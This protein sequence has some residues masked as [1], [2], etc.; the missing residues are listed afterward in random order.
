VA[1][2]REQGLE[3]EPVLFG[4][5]RRPEAA[6]LPYEMF[7]LLLDLAEDAAIAYRVRERIAT[8]DGARVSLADVAAELGVNLDEL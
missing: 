4:D 3:A 1:R 7:Q 2:F 6:L 5:R 8:D